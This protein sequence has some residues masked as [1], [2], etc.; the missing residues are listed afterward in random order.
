MSIEGTTFCDLCGEPVL[1][2]HIAPVKIEEGGRLQQFHFHNRH[3][4]DCLSQKLSQLTEEF[5]A[6]GQ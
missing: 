2:E 4:Q 3:S 1:A 5:A 6:A